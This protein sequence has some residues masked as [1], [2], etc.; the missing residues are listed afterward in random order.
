MPRE[1]KLT[2]DALKGALEWLTPEGQQPA[3]FSFCAECLERFISHKKSHTIITCKAHKNN[4]DMS[5]LVKFE[6]L[7]R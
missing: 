7:E 4:K 2:T 1:T 3:Y 6:T 5:L